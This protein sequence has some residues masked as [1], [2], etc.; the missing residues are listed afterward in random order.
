MQCTLCWRSLAQAGLGCLKDKQKYFIISTMQCNGSVSVKLSGVE[1]QGGGVVWW[2]CPPNI[3]F[4]D[5][6]NPH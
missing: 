3:I 5:L 4:Y 2:W 6:N 1:R